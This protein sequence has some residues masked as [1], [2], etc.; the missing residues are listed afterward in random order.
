MPYF[1]SW[2]VSQNSWGIAR[3]GQTVT[4]S[5]SCEPVVIETWLTSQNDNNI[6]F[7]GSM[8]THY[9]HETT[10]GASKMHFSDISGPYIGKF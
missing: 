2:S 10:A 5:I 8:Q 6:L 1:G 9:A 3:A 7:S 4:K